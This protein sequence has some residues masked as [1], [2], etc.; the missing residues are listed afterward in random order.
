[1]KKD[2]RIIELEDLNNLIA[3]PFQQLIDQKIAALV[4]RKQIEL[5]PS[6]FYTTLGDRLASASKHVIKHENLSVYP[7]T[8]AIVHQ[9]SSEDES[10]ALLNKFLEEGA[11][12]N[13]QYQQIMGKETIESLDSVLQKIIGEQLNLLSMNGQSFPKYNIRKMKP[14]KSYAI[15]IHCENSFLNQLNPS[16]KELLYKEVDIENALSFYSVLQKGEGGDLLLFENE[17]D[18]YKIQAGLLDESTRRNERLFFKSSAEVPYKRIKLN[19]GDLIVFRAGQIWHCIDE[20]S[21]ERD[22]I[23]IGGFIAESRKN[24]GQFL[25]WS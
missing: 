2:H 25:A 22:R 10:Y 16:L 14:G 24:K 13:K 21:G 3:S 9:K 1:M 4:F 20:I 15:E 19:G 11:I 18:D 12:A 8:Y 17:W 5:A 6:S 23:T 7:L